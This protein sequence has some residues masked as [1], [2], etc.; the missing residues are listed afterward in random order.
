M[1][2]DE[3]L[4]SAHAIMRMFERTVQR[5]DVTNAILGGE[6]I[7]EYM[8]DRPYP[9]YL[10]LWF[11]DQQPLHVVVARDEASYSCYVVTVY[12]PDGAVWDQGFKMRKQ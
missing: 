11:A 3:I 4:F 9:S 6:I 5:E 2:C 1:R 8:D 10:L 12:V 7:A